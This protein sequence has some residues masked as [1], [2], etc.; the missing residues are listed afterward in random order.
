MRH[1]TPS[2][3]PRAPASQCRRTVAAAV[4]A[5]CMCCVLQLL[6]VGCRFDSRRM[7]HARR[8]E[9]NPLETRAILKKKKKTKQNRDQA[10]DTDQTLYC[11]RYSGQEY[12]YCSRAAQRQEGVRLRS[13]TVLLMQCGS[14]SR[15][16]IRRFISR[17]SLP[18]VSFSVDSSCGRAYMHLSSNCSCLSLSRETNH[19]LGTARAGSAAGLFLTNVIHCM[20]IL[21][22]KKA[23][24]R[25]GGR[26]WGG[27]EVC[28]VRQQ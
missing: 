13:S 6:L 11:P 15:F 2:S 14:P 9:A 27:G 23:N 24:R 10:R 16:A 17:C 5:G 1:P 12:D 19:V 7:S 28:R 25:T 22:K 20:P 18:S 8:K 26:D 21:E 3:S 4:V